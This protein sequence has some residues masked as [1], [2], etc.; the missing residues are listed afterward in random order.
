MK[1]NAIIIRHANSTGNFEGIIQGRKEYHLSELGRKEI[2]DVVNENYNTFKDIDYVISSSMIRTYET[3]NDIL[4]LI[5]K[6]LNIEQMPYI[7]EVDSGIIAGKTHNEVEEKYPDYYKIWMSRKDLDGI[8]EAE[9][10]EE[11]QARCIGAAFIIGQKNFTKALIV[12]HA[13]FMR[14]FINTLNYRPRC[15]PVNVTNLD[16]HI[17]DNMDFSERFIN[18]NNSLKNKIYMYDAVEKKYVLKCFRREDKS[19]NSVIR[20]LK[21]LSNKIDFIQVPI[22]LWDDFPDN[23]IIKISE[24]KEGKVVFHKTKE[25][26]KDILNKIFLFHEN[27]N[28]NLTNKQNNCKTIKQKLAE[29]SRKIS[30]NSKEKVLAEILLA[31]EEIINDKKYVVWDDCHANNILINGD[32]ISFIDLESFVVSSVEYA[33]ASY[34]AAS[35]ILNEYHE[36][37]KSEILFYANLIEKVDSKTVLHM[38]VY[39]LATGLMYFK[40]KNI[41]SEVEKQLYKKYIDSMMAVCSAF[42]NEDKIFNM[43]SDVWGE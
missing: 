4:N 42:S 18:L 35:I 31:D 10:G 13:A 8:P 3:A 32:K 26:H 43:I 22:V 7:K 41:L 20:Y 19:C 29:I 6:N 5:H 15:T 9:K 39:R 21:K 16:F 1:K 28:E 2:V 24:F 33:I 36:I 11:L 40:N 12:T 30:N 38:I 14:C 17:I 23:E 25:Q 34:I 27:L 37:T